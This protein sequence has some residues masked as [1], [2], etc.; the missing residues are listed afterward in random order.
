MAQQEHRA[1]RHRQE[2]RAQQKSVLPR[3]NGRG[4]P[5][6]GLRAARLAAALSQRDLAA[7]IGSNQATICELEH[8]VRGAYP[9]TTRKLCRALNVEPAD[10]LLAG[11]AGEE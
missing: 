1:T 9:K 6:P 3:Q 5:L 4:A 7:A 2:L 8:L 10:L 11:T